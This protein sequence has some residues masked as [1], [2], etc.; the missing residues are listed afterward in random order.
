MHSNSFCTLP[1]TCVAN[2]IIFSTGE[3]VL[4]KDNRTTKCDTRFFS[5]FK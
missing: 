3:F 5:D 1:K 4:E 2:L